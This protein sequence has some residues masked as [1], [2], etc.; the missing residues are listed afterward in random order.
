MNVQLSE[1]DRLTLQG[2]VT[3][4]GSRFS[5]ANAFVGRVG[6][7]ARSTRLTAAGQ[8]ELG[9]GRFTT[10]ESGLRLTALPTRGAL[11]AEPRAAL[12]YHR[13]QT[14][15]GEVAARIGGGLYRQYTTQFEVSRDGA[16]AVVPTAQVWM[17][18]PTR[19]QPPKAYHLTSS[20]TWGPHPAWSV[21]VEGYGKW[22]PH[23]L[24]VDY[25]ALQSEAPV[26]VA[27]PSAILSASQG[28]AYGGGLRLAYEGAWGRSTLRYAYSR[29]RR[30][31]PGRFGG[32]MISTPWN[33]PHRV[34]L[35]TRLPLNDVLPVPCRS[36][37]SPHVG[38]TP[39]LSHPEQHRLPPLYR[40]DASLVASHSWGDVDITGRIGL[41][42][43]LGRT[44]VADWGLRPTGHGG[45]TRRARTLPGRRSVLSLQVR[46]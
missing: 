7:T 25:P 6:T 2:G 16:T 19:A 31:F 24:A 27:P 1:R 38:S 18:V 28:H 23:L 4:L 30:T 26:H 17:P 29:S 20:L 22:K 44:N 34:T 42:N 21:G 39:D 8:V 40:L 14:A 12:H 3:S 13:P 43:A 41:V 37:D 9:L 33:E 46:Y 15:L 45:V 32:R 10:L 35:D 11:F 5:L 36:T